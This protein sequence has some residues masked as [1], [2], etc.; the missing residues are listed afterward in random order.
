[1]IFQNVTGAKRFDIKLGGKVISSETGFVLTEDEEVINYLRGRKDFVGLG[2]QP[3]PK[4]TVIR[5][6]KAT[7]GVDIPLEEKAP[8]VEIPVKKIKKDKGEKNE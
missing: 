5:G 6:A 7:E 4:P 3:E 2:N 1:M 8:E